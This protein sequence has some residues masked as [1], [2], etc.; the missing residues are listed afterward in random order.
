[1]NMY[2][3]ILCFVHKSNNVRKKGG[4]RES[5]IWAF[6]A[7]VQYNEDDNKEE[8]DMTNKWKKKCWWLTSAS[9]FLSMLYDSRLH[10]IDQQTIQS[11][12]CKMLLSYRWKTLTLSLPFLEWHAN[13]RERNLINIQWIACNFQCLIEFLTSKHKLQKEEL[14]IFPCEND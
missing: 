13:K 6:S 9:V 2:V 14:Y 8:L 5:Y 3:Y 10:H 11:K 12:L 4:N 7:T 1:M